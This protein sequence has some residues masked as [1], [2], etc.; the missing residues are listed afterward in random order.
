M[1]KPINK[2]VIK[3]IVCIAIICLMCGSIFL[4]MNIA[5]NSS[6]STPQMSESGGTPP[7]NSGGGPG[8]DSNSSSNGQSSN[9]NDGSTNSNDQSSNSSDESSNSS[10]QSSNTPP[11]LPSNNSGQSSNAPSMN[12]KGSSS[13]GV[14]YYV[15][16][17]VEG[18][19]ISITAVYLILSKGNKKTFKE[20][21][22]ST[23]GLLIGGLCVVV[24]TAGISYLSGK[25]T[26]DYFMNN[27]APSGEIKQGNNSSNTSSVD[28][29][30]T[31]EVTEDDSLT[32]QTYDNTSSDEN[33]VL[34]SGKI[35]ANISD[36]TITKS[37]DASSGDNSNFYGNNS[38]IISKDGANLT[39]KNITVST[40]ASGANGVFS[41]GGSAS[42]NNSSSDGTT[43]NISD[44]K[45]TTTGD[46]AGGIMTT[47]GGTTKATN[48]TVNT[49]GT[50][51]AAIRSDRGGGTV[52]VNKGT[53][54]TTGTGSPTIYSTSNTK[55]SNATLTA[56]ASEGVVIEGANSVTLNNCNLTDT[57]TTLNGQ[58]TTY[59]NIFLYQSMS[60]D[61]SNGSANFTSKNSTITTNKGDTFY[62]TNTSAKISLT[63]NTIT[64]NDSSG[65]FLRVQKD[66]WGKEGSNGGKVTLKMNN[67][68][69]TGNIVVDSISTLKMKMSNGSYYEGT[70]NGDNSA[71]KITLTL[72]KTSKIKLTGDSYVSSLTD[73]VSDYSNIDFNGYTLYVNGTAINK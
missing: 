46:N 11:D 71:K 41:Y 40:T 43:V 14:I 55:V 29:S 72:D 62:V 50:S 65:N 73:S 23:K 57:N 17:A 22:S 69:A 51:S 28:Y 35:D 54:T 39:L 52:I 67:Q 63:N 9:S 24:A 16:Y 61:A 15:V 26:S 25:I 56:S 10:D 13:L 58:S 33:T 45:I 44:S 4:T 38:A 49:S 31:K 36:S 37:G 3:N 66:S 27:N 48:L 18:A 47:G 59:K 19:V 32:G 1:K 34:V 42:T 8:Q 5:R 70:I 53:Y 20:T 30:A 12:S 2:R 60:G 64:N 7:S 21:M 6:S 68:S